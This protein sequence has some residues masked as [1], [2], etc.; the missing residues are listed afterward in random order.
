ML[1]GKKDAE[2]IFLSNILTFPPLKNFPLIKISY[3]YYWEFKLGSPFDVSKSKLLI[4]KNSIMFLGN[5]Y[6]V[7][8][9]KKS[10]N[11]AKTIC[12]GEGAELASINSSQTFVKGW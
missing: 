12:E 2:F 9:E 7:I 5:C 3:P 6:R 8:K 10:W 4:I 1:I 11:E